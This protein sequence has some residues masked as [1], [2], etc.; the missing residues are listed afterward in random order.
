MNTV[1]H[2]AWSFSTNV[3]ILKYMLLQYHIPVMFNI[4]TCIIYEGKASV[5]ICTV[6][7]ER[8]VYEPLCPCGRTRRCGYGAGVLWLLAGAVP[9]N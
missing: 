2:T 3:I 7:V 6:Y 9:V 4:F 5:D 1:I 8:R